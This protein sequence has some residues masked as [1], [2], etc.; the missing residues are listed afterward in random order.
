MD[1]IAELVGFD[2]DRYDQR[3]D[4][5]EKSSDNALLNFAAACGIKKSNLMS[6]SQF[7][8]TFYFIADAYLLLSSPSALSDKVNVVS[9]GVY[10]TQTNFENRG[11]KINLTKI[12]DDDNISFILWLSA[13]VQIF[14][15]VMLNF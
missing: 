11:W 2:A 5:Q 13:L 10:Q 1:R 9:H 4:Q 8:I 7:L 12:F 15:G 3:G 14:C 6:I